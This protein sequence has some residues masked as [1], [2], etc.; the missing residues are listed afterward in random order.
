L[1]E[2]VHYF[3]KFRE[4]FA[5]EEHKLILTYRSAR[6]I[7][8]KTN[9]M[10]VNASRGIGF[11]RMKEGVE[12][13]AFRKT[14]GIVVH[15]FNNPTQRLP[16]LLD[17]IMTRCSRRNVQETTAVLCRTNR[18][19]RQVF[20]LLRHHVDPSLLQVLGSEDFVLYQLRPTGA[21]LDMCTRRDPWDF[22]EPYTWDSLLSE[23][24]DLGHADM[25]KSIEELRDMYRL[26][27]IECGRPRMQNVVDFVQE[28]RTSDIER[29]KVRTGLSAST[30]RITISTVHKVKGLEYDTVVVLPSS[31][32]F[33]L[34]DSDGGEVL[35]TDAA[36]EAR[37]CYVAM[38][39]AR[40]RLYVGWPQGGRERH[41]WARRRF[42]G[43]SQNG[44]YTLQGIYKENYV[45][46]AGQTAQVEHGIQDYIEQQVNAGDRVELRYGQAIYHH[47]RKVGRLKIATAQRLGER[48]GRV[49]LRIANVIRYTAGE[50][51]KIHKPHFYDQLHPM[52]KQ[53]RWFYMVLPEEG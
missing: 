49:S 35:I 6:K 36:E 18:E 37:L 32:R 11:Q 26:M 2:V 38:T 50:Y 16:P 9:G 30:H 48:A 41:W 24:Q 19:C 12:I 53:R 39:R 25:A 1:F 21:I 28:M 40:N 20:E 44:S 17:K 8:C 51:M 10:I 42:E 22:I 29:L 31:E 15:P 43:N 13:K 4:A 27:R 34:N 5:P 47:G 7:I 3:D 52:I 33:P 23:Y 45:S 14:T 46:W